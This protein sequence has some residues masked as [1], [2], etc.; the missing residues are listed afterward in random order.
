MDEFGVHALVLSRVVGSGREQLE[1]V[2]FAPRSLAHLE[3]TSH[4]GRIDASC[5][6]A[7]RGCGVGVKREHMLEDFVR[8]GF[9]SGGQVG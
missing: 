5:E 3:A 7:A 2:V 4:P 8:L 9:G 1:R 6:V